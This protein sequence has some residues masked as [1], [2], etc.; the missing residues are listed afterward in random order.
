MTSTN[1]VRPS[2]D[3]DQFHYLW[4]ARRC[5]KLLLNGDLVA[6]SIEGISLREH[7]E[8]AQITEGEELIDVAEYFGSEDLSKA[9]LVRYLQLKHSTL[10]ASK[11]WTASGLEKTITGF[12][13]RYVELSK[14]YSQDVLIQ[15]LEFW[16]VT[17]RPISLDVREA[18]TD[19]SSNVSTPRHPQ[20]VVKLK[21]FTGLDDVELAVFCGLLHFE[22]R[23]DGY[24]DQRN[25]LLQET[26]GYLPDSDVDAPMQLKE[27]VTRR[28]LSEGEQNPVITKVDVLRALKTD[29]S[30]LFPAKCLIEISGDIVAREQELEVIDAIVATK[31]PIIIH[32]SGGV[33]KSIMA[34]QIAR[35]I[36]SNSV[37][38]L[39]DCFGNGEYRSATG[40]RHRHKDALVQIANEL[41][42][43]GLCHPLI[44]TVHADSTAYLKAFMYRLT[45][46]IR[47]LRASDPNALLCIVVDAADN[48]QMA[49][50]EIGEKRSFVQDLIRERIPDGAR[51]IFL[52]RSHRQDLLCPPLDTTSIELLPFSLKETT[53][54]LQKNFPS[55]TN[56]DI[57]EF[58]SL[59]SQNPRVQALALSQNKPL[60]DILRLLGPGPMSVDDMISGL[61]DSAINNLKDVS[62][63]I[64]KE[65]IEKI[66]VGMSALR[67][68]IP[69]QTLS[70]ISGVE[71]EA[72]KSFAYDIGRPLLIAG[73]TI[74]FF[75]EPAE[76]WF[77]DKFKPNAHTM[78]GFIESLKPIANK[79]A[80]VASVLPQLMLEAGQLSEL[81]QLALS[82]EAIPDVNLFEKKDIELR[83]LQFALK[84][85]L[86]SKRYLEVTK[87]SL[88]AGGEAAGDQR[89]RSLLQ[90]NVDL[91]S[92]F[93]GLDLIQD[94]VSRRIFGSGWVGSH[95][96]Y[97][98]AL[99]SGVGGTVGD[100]RSRLRMAYEWLQNWARLA[101][102]ER[103]REKVSDSDIVALVIAHLNINGPDVAAKELRR[104]RPRGISYRVGR[105]LICRLVDH[106]RWSDIDALAQA[107][108]NNIYLTFAIVVELRR[109]NKTLSSKVMEKIFRRLAKGR[110]KLRDQF[111]WDGKDVE[112]DDVMA[113]V[114]ASLINGLCGRDEAA[115][116]IRNYLPAEPP[117]E[118]VSRALGKS[119]VYL[120]AYCLL[121]GLEEK[122]IELID[123]A[124]IE[125]RK[126]IE[127]DLQHKTSRE[128]SEFKEVIGMLLPWYKLWASVFLRQIDEDEINSL[129]QKLL[130]VQKGY[131]A[132]KSNFSNDIA[133]LWMDII[134]QFEKVNG[135][136][137]SL[138]TYWKNQLIQPLFT[139]T[140]NNICRLCAQKDETKGVA[141][142]YAKEAYALITEERSEAESK[143]ERCIE[144]ARAVLIISNSEAKAYFEESMR[145][146]GRIGDENLARW[147]AMIYLANKAS[148]IETPEPKIA[149]QLAR[150]AELTYDYVHRDKHFPWDSTVIALCGLCPSSTITILSRWRDRVFGWHG[151]L[152]PIAMN[153][154]I[155]KD[156]VEPFDVLPMVGFRAQWNYSRLL[157]SI[158]TKKHSVEE[159]ACA[160]ATLHRYIQFSSLP[161]SDLKSFHKVA[162]NSGIK[163]PRLA[164][165]ILSLEKVEEVREYRS[166]NH[167]THWERN[168]ENKIIQW[169]EVFADAALMTEH[170]FS[171]AYKSFRE[172]EVSWK[173]EDFFAEAIRRI[174]FGV[175]ADFVSA[176]MAAPEFNLYDVNTFLNQFPDDWKGRPAI[177]HAL[178]KALKGLCRRYY[179]DVRRYLNYEVFPFKTVSLL[180]GIDEVDIIDVVLD[181][182]GESADLIVTERLFS[183]IGLLAMK[184]SPDEAL[185]ALR[186]GLDL[187][188]SA[189]EDR[190][191]DGP[192]SEVFL[193]PDDIRKAIAGYI[194]SALASP[195]ATLRWEAAHAVFELCRLNR[196]D[197]LKYLIEMAI[198]KKG[199]AFVDARLPF[200]ELHALQ[201]LIIGLTRGAFEA[202]RSVAPYGQQ[203]VDWALNGQPHV[204][205]RKISARAAL[206]LIHSGELA[207]ENGLSSSLINV[208]KPLLP[209]AFS[210]NDQR[211]SVYQNEK[212]SEFDEDSFYFGIDIGPYWYAPLGRVFSL[213]EGD[214]E[215]KALNVLSMNLAYKEKGRRAIDE[216]ANR[217]LYKE[218]HIYHSHG[219]YPR[220][221]NLHFYYAYHAMMIVAG[222]LLETTAV[223][224]EFDDD[225]DQF[226]DWL[227]IHDL[228]RPNG[229][230]LSDR[231]DPEP[232]IKGIWLDRDKD[233]PDYRKLT[234]EE[235]YDALIISG[236][237]FNLW[238]SWVEADDD[239]EQS[240]QIFSALVTSE[241]SEALLC[242]LSS[243]KDIHDYVIP[244]SGGYKEI[245]APGFELKGWVLDNNGSLRLDEYDPWGGGITPIPPCPAP[246]VRECMRLETDSDLRF[247]WDQSKTLVL[248]SEVWGFFDE[249]IRNESSNLNRGC[250]LQGSSLFIR[251]MLEELNRDL[252]IK[253]QIGRRRSYKWYGN[254]EGSDDERIENTARL[255]LFDSSGKLRTI[256]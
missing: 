163:L 165:E 25:I 1:L 251:K 137:L 132:E 126:E 90:K 151:R 19:L 219:S 14:R 12:S 240:I 199:G 198:S 179:M 35:N 56:R 141:L 110:F 184:L 139:S 80:Y 150:C 20:E 192:W 154:L 238:G 209:D 176:V 11:P 39:Y 143:A 118:L 108:E 7:P 227:L 38:I 148:K 196:Q 55:A 210:K 107:A 44:P 42:A 68:L 197:I 177:S 248:E 174:P 104:W 178:D 200:Y 164:E 51:F 117:R 113:V 119:A 72:I 101:P 82:S 102:E 160:G 256:G 88:K 30:Q 17:N 229:R 52:C 167:E 202:P 161:V 208:N 8:K 140:L 191:G 230:W 43:K 168:E 65:Q 27:L 62:S 69:I 195:E 217:N 157:E 243:V 138:F 224:N 28:A 97:D 40:Y 149:F 162:E 49:A 33:G 172:T 6:V 92:V 213:S 57:E 241:K 103:E 37:S 226:D 135:E 18:V 215:R 85:G 22:D 74:Q 106:G 129:V 96:A 5:L 189:V 95:H 89:Q 183:L 63:T 59:S 50:M 76:T 205:I 221:D 116:I 77:R 87:L 236:D 21:K 58:H 185:D 223:N 47:V 175:E 136:A 36:P 61:L 211:N 155:E 134:H 159:E 130:S 109:V 127:E 45:Q 81:V 204:L 67:P 121:A 181:A 133:I 190:D 24:W 187:F 252:I 84:A 83:R 228:S 54:L 48:A 23:E 145:L 34:T 153:N 242:A 10:H 70:A 4:A 186:Y 120:R 122:S 46:A 193:P 201:W 244:S 246:F 115:T 123:V 225:V 3:G 78:A 170:G 29:E 182:T 249:A 255:F 239:R 100:A 235:F 169:D 203:L 114:E 245:E 158:S 75:D 15:M 247:W 93:L 180:A 206:Q 166:S 234:T 144:V 254:N 131:Y 216:R 112:I 233:H 220:S 94:L 66:C 71:P 98:A 152:L 250:R 41:A 2:R 147:D 31:T 91:S 142:S 188:D 26:S 222:Q 212:S 146:A 194:W 9:K 73:D 99:L 16:F 124:H 60:Q 128:L 79:S 53:E 64:E 13:K 253:V 32:A 173:R 105:L 218:G 125:L 207:D 237:K 231:R 111:V 232:L 86:R 214:I 156:I 171:Q